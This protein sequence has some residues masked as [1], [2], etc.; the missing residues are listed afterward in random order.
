MLAFNKRFRSLIL[1]GSNEESKSFGAWD[2]HKEQL[3][4]P[5]AREDFTKEAMITKRAKN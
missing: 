1:R 3:I 2:T 4:L 5:L